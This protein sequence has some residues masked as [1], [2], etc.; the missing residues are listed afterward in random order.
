MSLLRHQNNGDRTVTAHSSRSK[1]RRPC[2]STIVGAASVMCRHT[3]KMIAIIGVRGAQTKMECINHAYKLMIQESRGN[4][5]TPESHN[6]HAACSLTKELIFPVTCTLFGPR[7]SPLLCPCVVLHQSVIQ[8]TEALTISQLAVISKPVLIFS[9]SLPWLYSARIPIFSLSGPE[10]EAM[11]KYIQESLK[12]R[13]IRHLS[14]PAGAGFFFGAKV[15]TKLDEWK[16]AFITPKGHYEYLFLPFGLT[17]APRLPG[18]GTHSACAPGPP[19]TVGEPAICQ[20]G[21]LGRLSLI[22]PRS[23]LLRSSKR[24]LG[25]ANFYWRLIRN[26]GQVAA[27]LTALTSIKVPFTWSAQEAFDNLKSRFIFAPVLSV[28]DPERQFIVEVYASDVGPGPK[29]VKPDALSH[30][31]ERP[32]RSLRPMAY[33]L[34]GWSWGPSSEISSLRCLVSHNPASYSQQL[35]WARKA[36]AQSSRRTKAAADHHRTPASRYVC[37]QKVWLSTKD[38]PLKAAS[39]KVKPVFRSSLNANMS[40]PAPPPLR[41]VDG[42]PVYSVRRLLDVRC[43]GWGFQYLV[44][45]GGLWSRGEELGSGSGYSESVA[46]RGLLPETK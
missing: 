12:A 34:R 42:S 32:E 21:E 40:S 31:F 38:L 13:L 18:H 16:T 9:C 33:S 37:G 43:H 2:Q 41:L 36:L 17:N 1:L 46:D 8:C 11:D 26:F 23:R 29:N 3:D 35:S 25:F 27:P 10:R 7:I 4:G 30:Q 14:S 20:G 15:S 28:P 5:V 6:E 22:Q 39:H 24:F 44:D 19:K 45:W